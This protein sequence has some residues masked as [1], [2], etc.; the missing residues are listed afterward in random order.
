MYFIELGIGVIREVCET[1]DILD[2]VACSHMQHFAMHVCKAVTYERLAFLI[3]PLL[4]E[5]V[6]IRTSVHFLR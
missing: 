1:A 3:Y 5:C 4:R 2:V 6:L